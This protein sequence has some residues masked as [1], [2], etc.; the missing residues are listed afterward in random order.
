M[1]IIG[2]KYR[3]RKLDIVGKETTRETA[4]MVKEAVF[5]ML[6]GTLHGT[7]LD[8]FAGSGA[9]GLEGISRGALF[10]YLVDIDIDAIK[11]IIHNA[12][13]MNET[14]NVSIHHKSYVQ[15]IS[16]LDPKVT[17]DYV[18]LDPPYH[19]VVYEEVIKLLKPYL[20]EDSIIICESKKDVILPE[21]IDTLEKVK[22][23]TYGIKRISIYQKKG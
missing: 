23:K 7:I 16:K 14:A 6:G 8:L 15:F 17:F 5:N 19:M 2:G 11:T 18:F 4:D 3:G 13:K 1:R 21:S 12:K 20:L 9:Y 22:E 10:A